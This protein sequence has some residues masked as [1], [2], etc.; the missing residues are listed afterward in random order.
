MGKLHQKTRAQSKMAAANES[1]RLDGG[2]EE[3]K[4]NCFDAWKARMG[5]KCCCLAFGRIG[6]K[7]LG[8]HRQPIMKTLALLQF[9]GSIFC[10]VGSVGL[11]TNAT[12]LK[13]T[14]WAEYTYEGTDGTGEHS[15]YM[16]LA[17]ARV[18]QPKGDDGIGYSVGKWDDFDDLDEYTSQ[19]WFA[20]IKDCKDASVKAQ[21][22][23][24]LVAI[25]HWFS[26]L[27]ALTRSK[28]KSDNGCNKILAVINSTCNATMLLICTLAFGTQ[29]VNNISDTVDP[30][31]GV[32]YS[33]VILACCIDLFIGFPIHLLT[34]CPCPE[35]IECELDDKE[36]FPI[37]L[38]HIA[39]NGTNY[40]SVVHAH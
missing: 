17:G 35:E 1:G 33:L 15:V 20:Q 38:D 25:F 6:F 5:K 4:L 31:F 2:C 27:D 28:V 40:D 13:S 16:N 39:A 29:C 11:S 14:P 3:E 23:M 24:L 37:A 19:P 12:V 7:A 34:P 18:D 26:S 9:A 21:T 32:A 36:Q 30:D 10:I 8:C 22:T